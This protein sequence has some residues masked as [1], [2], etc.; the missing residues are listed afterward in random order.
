MGV[1]EHYEQHLSHVYAWMSG[2]FEQQV[3]SFQSFLEEHD[4]VPNASGVAVDL[5]AG[6]G[7]QTMA[8]VR[9]GFQVTAIDFSEILL[10]ELLTISKDH[11]ITTISGDITSVKALVQQNPEL[12]VCCGDT[13]SHLSDCNA[14]EQLLIDIA[15]VLAE[16]GKLILSFRDYSIERRG[17]ERVIPVKSDTHQI[18]TCILDYESTHVRV[19]DLLYTHTNEGWISK[20]SSYLKIRVT[21]VMIRDLLHKSGFSL[22]VDTVINHMVYMIASKE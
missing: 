19:T 1:K 18:L 22:Q 4:I 13:I 10:Q 8:L 15:E 21:P 9:Q 12:M 6:H 11:S 2:D 3:G 20:V 14:I 5:G 7:I 17:D 16:K